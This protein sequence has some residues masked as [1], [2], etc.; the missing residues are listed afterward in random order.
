MMAH[1]ECWHGSF[2][3]I[4]GIGTSIAKKT[5]SPWMKITIYHIGL[6]GLVPPYC[7]LLKNIGF[8][9]L[10]LIVFQKFSFF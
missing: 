2:V 3:I 1:I 7:A 10:D 9:D 4:Q 8:I 5:S 6:P